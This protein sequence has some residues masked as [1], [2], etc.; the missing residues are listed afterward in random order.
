MAFVER[1]A[2][3]SKPQNGRRNG[4]K[5]GR[6]GKGGKGGGDSRDKVKSNIMKR[7]RLNDELRELQARVDNYVS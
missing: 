7:E 6:G 4:Q 5:G 1:R 3:S 2:S